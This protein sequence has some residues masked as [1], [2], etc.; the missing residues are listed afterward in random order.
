MAS[1]AIN[2]ITVKNILFR[3]AKL[4]SGRVIYFFVYLYTCRIYGALFFNLRA[5][6]L[7]QWALA[8]SGLGRSTLLH[9]PSKMNSVARERFTFFSA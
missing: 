6:R 7:R 2:I 4:F 5:P 3:Q 1:L 8:A 9:F